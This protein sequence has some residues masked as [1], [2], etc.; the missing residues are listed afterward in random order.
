M[1]KLGEIFRCN[2]LACLSAFLVIVS[3]LFGSIKSDMAQI[4]QD[5]SALY[6]FMINRPDRTA[7]LSAEARSMRPGAP[8]PR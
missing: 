5:I 4:R 8:I 6:S 1:K 7:L 3:L 2:P